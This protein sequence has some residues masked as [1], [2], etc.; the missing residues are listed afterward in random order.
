[1]AFPI[2]VS[3][4]IMKDNLEKRKSVLPISR[5]D[6]QR[7]TKGLNLPRGGET[8]LYTGC[9]YQ[10]IPYISATVK[11]A[12]KYGDSGL[13]NLARLG[14]TLNKVVSLTGFMTL[15]SKTQEEEYHEI[16]RSI[17][18][19][20][21]KAGVEFGYL[22]D[23]DYYAGALLYDLGVDES[24]KKHAEFVYRNLKKHGVK[25]IIT[26]D[27]HTTN[28]MRQ[29]YPEIIPE[30]DVEV[31]SYLEVLAENIDKLEP[32]REV[33]QTV[34]IHDSCVYA[35]YEGVIDEPRRLLEKAGYKIVEPDNA[36]KLTFCCGGPVES[37]YP[38]KALNI[39]KKRVDELDRFGKNVVTMCPIC[40]A[41]LSRATDV[42]TFKDIALYL[43]DAFIE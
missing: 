35:R 16:L 21:Q 41:N 34:V 8:V 32:V 37:L 5:K 4:G 30:F 15:F 42:L 10:L 3:I 2:D 24:V 14:R 39:A 17:V 1:M 9:M 28:L 31:K 40:L 7:W 38:E 26:V 33:N 36:G 22:Y 13:K 23:D 27:P 43:R 29:V 25:K 6:A 19:L 20:L 18:K 11:Y 12:E